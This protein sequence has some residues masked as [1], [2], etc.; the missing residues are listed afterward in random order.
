MASLEE[1]EDAIAGRTKQCLDM[2]ERLAESL[3]YETNEHHSLSP[4]L[5]DEFEAYRVWVR[6]SGAC[7]QDHASLD[8]RLRDNT[9]TRRLF[10]TILDGLNS[11]LAYCRSRLVSEGTLSVW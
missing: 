6:N 9:P 11:N 1:V 7:A 10:L 4:D 3:A 2:F 8:Y 5:Q